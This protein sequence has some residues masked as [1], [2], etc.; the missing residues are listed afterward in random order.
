MDENNLDENY[1]FGYQTSIFFRGSCVRLSASLNEGSVCVNDFV[2]ATSNL[3]AEKVKTGK[4]RRLR[5]MCL[6]GNRGRN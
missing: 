2:F 3:D 6:R 4:F 5:S 1:L